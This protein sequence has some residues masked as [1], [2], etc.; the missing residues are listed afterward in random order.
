MLNRTATILYNKE[1]IILDLLKKIRL[2]TLKYKHPLRVWIGPKLFVY[3]S[4][5]QHVE[6]NEKLSGFQTQ[7]TL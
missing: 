7:F 6:V 1:F 3:F 2:T 4:S 5:A